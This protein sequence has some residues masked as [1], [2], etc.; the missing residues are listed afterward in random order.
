VIELRGSTAVT[1]PAAGTTAGASAQLGSTL[2]LRDTASISASGDGIRASTLTA[3]DISGNTV[4]GGA[5]SFGVNCFATS[6]M[7]GKEEADWWVDHTPTNLR[8]ARLLT[9]WFPEARFIHIVRDPGRAASVMPL[10]WG[11]NTI[12]EAAL[13]WKRRMALALT[14]VD[15]SKAASC[16]RGKTGQWESGPKRESCT[17]FHRDRARP[18]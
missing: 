17:A 10:N 18:S 6:P 2:R 4:Q 13:F 11:P 14:S 1:V 15:T 16:G 12:T 3:V 5:G 8:F 7:T 9:A